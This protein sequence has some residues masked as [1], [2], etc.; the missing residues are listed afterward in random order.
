M[1]PGIEI[2][3]GT[4]SS[5]LFAFSSK[6]GALLEEKSCGEIKAIV[7]GTNETKQDAFTICILI[8]ALRSG[9]FLDKR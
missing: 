5:L 7:K 8:N 3:S 1:R 4:S 6:M 9:S 2:C